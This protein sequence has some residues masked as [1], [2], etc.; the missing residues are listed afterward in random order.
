ML[1]QEKKKKQLTTRYN[2]SVYNLWSS[3]LIRNCPSQNEEYD[4]KIPMIDNS[5]IKAGLS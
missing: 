2:S 4:A 1:A 5:Y 3:L